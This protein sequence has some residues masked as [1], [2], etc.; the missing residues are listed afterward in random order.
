MN[1]A[2]D[3]RMTGLPYSDHTSTQRTCSCSTYS[4]FITRGAKILASA[5]PARW[6]KM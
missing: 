6:A 3:I 4:L 1:C 2:Y 5:V